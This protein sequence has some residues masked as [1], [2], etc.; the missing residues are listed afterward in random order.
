MTQ[1]DIKRWDVVLFDNSNTQVPMIYIKPDLQFL[2]YVKKNNFAVI[3]KISGSGTVYDG[4]T[5]PGIVDKSC[6]VP[7]YR[8]NYFEKTGY[9]IVTLN[10][11]WYGYPNSKT[12]GKV[13][14]EGIVKPIVQGEVPKLAPYIAKS[15]APKQT[16]KQ[17]TSD[18]GMS[19]YKI[20]L[21]VSGSILFIAL[22]ALI[23]NRMYK[24]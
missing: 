15:V 1:F 16:Q 21:I 11:N 7:N 23:I 13:S 18:K 19:T 14:F 10:A 4:K 9:Y 24:K 5:I 6:Y 3:A 2:E 8:P 22:L 20:A 17:T 12:L